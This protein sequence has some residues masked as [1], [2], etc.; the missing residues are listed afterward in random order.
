[1]YTL[2]NFYIKLNKPDNL[3]D[4]KFDSFCVGCT[5][6]YKRLLRKKLNLSR[7]DYIDRIVK[8]NNLVNLSSYGKSRKHLTYDL[9]QYMIKNVVYVKDRL[10]NPKLTLVIRQNNPFT[11]NIEELSLY[12]RLIEYGNGDIKPLNIFNSTFAACSNEIISNFNKL[13]N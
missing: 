9:L 7:C 10:S 1:M 13:F 6:Q 4:A 5:S 8:S 3:S 2:F 12:I 11:S